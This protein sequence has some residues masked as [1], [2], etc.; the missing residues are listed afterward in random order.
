MESRCAPVRRDC[1]DGG[2]D[3]LVTVAI[4]LILRHRQS[5]ASS[6]RARDPVNSRAAL[7]LGFRREDA[8]SAT[9]PPYGDAT[10]QL[11]GG[12]PVGAVTSITRA[13]ITQLLTT[14]VAERIGAQGETPRPYLSMNIPGGDAHNDELE[15]RYARRIHRGL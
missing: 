2:V 15:M 14:G 7:R 3:D 13:F 4:G 12:V 10:V 5:R 9:S 11:A 8:H 6:S 1:D